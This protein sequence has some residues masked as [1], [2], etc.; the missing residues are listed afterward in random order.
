MVEDREKEVEV[1]EESHEKQEQGCILVKSNAQERSY[2]QT[3]HEL[4]EDNFHSIV[5]LEEEEREV[6]EEREPH[7][8]R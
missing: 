4:D 3:T 2:K 5:L 8:R 6:E 1:E 7:M